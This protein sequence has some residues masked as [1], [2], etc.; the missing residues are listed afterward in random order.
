[1]GKNG[2]WPNKEVP[3]PYV[4]GNKSGEG[5]PSNTVM[6]VLW[7]Y[8]YRECRENTLRLRF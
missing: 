2:N 6:V 5:E 3:M 1:M 7:T 8:G 4:A